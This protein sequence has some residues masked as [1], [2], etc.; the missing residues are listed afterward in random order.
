MAASL[1]REATLAAQPASVAVA[2]RLVREALAESGVTDEVA[3]DTVLAASELVANAVLHAGGPVQ[4]R[5]EVIDDDPLAIRLEVGDRSPVLPSVRDYDPDASTGRGLALVARLAFRWGIE[6]AVEPA[7]GKLVWCELKP[8][9]DTAKQ[10]DPLSRLAPPETAD[11]P[12][13]EPVQF[14]GVPVDL[15]LQLQEQNDG[16]LR[17]LAL[18]ALTVDLEGEVQPSPELFDVSQQ[19]T[20][21]FNMK[22]EGFRREVAVAAAQGEVCIDLL[23]RYSPSTVDA[24][25]EYIALFERAEA[26]AEREEMLISPAPPAVARLRRW[27]ITEMHGQLVERRPPQP[28]RQDSDLER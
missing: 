2:R 10:T 7:L 3:E 12:D 17:E 8:G 23:G 18:L 21:Y 15:Y 14:L 13:A 16:V 4:L 26:L 19:A 11:A 25:E 22:R 28:F 27:F 5:L 9:D 1:T 6:P 24:A 20:A